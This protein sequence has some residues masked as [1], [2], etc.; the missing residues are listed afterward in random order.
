MGTQ[1]SSFL[2]KIF[3]FENEQPGVCFLSLDC[4]GMTWVNFQGEENQRTTTNTTTTTTITTTTNITTT[5][6]ISIINVPRTYEI[7]KT[8]T[9]K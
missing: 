1:I 7:L 6:I 3:T 8:A 5:T 2:H 4:V 9:F